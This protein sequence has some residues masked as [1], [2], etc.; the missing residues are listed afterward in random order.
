MI[1][2]P[3]RLLHHAVNDRTPMGAAWR[4]PYFLRSVLQYCRSGGRAIFCIRCP[5]RARR[6]IRAMIQSGGR[7][8]KIA[9]LCKLPCPLGN[10]PFQ[11]KAVHRRNRGHGS[12]VS[13][14][15]RGWDR[16]ISG[17]GRLR[18]FSRKQA[19]KGVRVS[20]QQGLS[21]ACGVCVF[22]CRCTDCRRPERS[23]FALHID[24]Q[25]FR[26]ASR[27]NI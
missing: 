24:E 20:A 7:D 2:A 5:I 19:A 11:R 4:R 18:D 13:C 14:S 27:S 12:P 22:R 16:R 15:G 10:T 26:C 21:R 1:A 23:I 8:R 3:H 17:R 9:C 6:C 25:K